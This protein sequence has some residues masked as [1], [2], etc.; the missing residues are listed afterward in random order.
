M[1]DGVAEVFI[2]FL[3]FIMYHAVHIKPHPNLFEH[4]DYVMIHAELFF[5]DAA[6]HFHPQYTLYA[7]LYSIFL[8]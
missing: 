6:S 2:L 1:E 5:S 8:Q 3:C 4:Q 7:H